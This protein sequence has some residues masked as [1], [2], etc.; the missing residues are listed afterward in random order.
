MAR[1]SRPVCGPFAGDVL[2]EE[3]LDQI[4]DG[5]GPALGLDLGQGIAAGVDQAL[6]PARL[7][8]GGRCL[9]VG[10]GPDRVAALA[11]RTGAVAQD[12]GAMPAAVTRAPKPF[13]SA[14]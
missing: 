4:V 14:S 12:E 2:F 9:P 5:R 3:A 1:G 8:A 6:E 11:A 7:L 13:T 10:E